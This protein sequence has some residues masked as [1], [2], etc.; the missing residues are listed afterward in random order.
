M[1]SA[2]ATV[3][4]HTRSAAPMTRPTP[5]DDRKWWRVN[6]RYWLREARRWHQ[7]FGGEDH[8]TAVLLHLEALVRAARYRGWMLAA[9]AS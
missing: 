6:C 9:R 8:E 3:T 7:Q 1:H 5:F 4:P 2:L